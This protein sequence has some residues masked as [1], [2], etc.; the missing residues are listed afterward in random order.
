MGGRLVSTLF[1][2]ADMNVR[3]LKSQTIAK[4][5]SQLA[6]LRQIALF[7]ACGIEGGVGS[8]PVP[9]HQSFKIPLG[10]LL[11]SRPQ[12]LVRCSVATDQNHCCQ[13]HPYPTT[14]PA[15]VPLSAAVAQG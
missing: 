15:H 9:P 4:R 13:R 11:C 8:G 14:E 2:G 12:R 1:A 7:L 6:E 3:R 5:L 10:A